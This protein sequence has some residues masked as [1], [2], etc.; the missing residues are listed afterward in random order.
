VRTSIDDRRVRAILI[1]LASLAL[2]DCGG[3]GEGGSA[4]GCA[5]GLETHTGAAVFSGGMSAGVSSVPGII[6]HGEPVTISGSGFGVKS[7]ALPAV[8]DGASGTNILDKWDGF[9]PS[10]NATYNLAYRNLPPCLSRPH[11]RASNRVISGAH[12]SSGGADAGFNV[13]FWK[14]RTITSYPAYTYASWYQRMDNNWVFGSDDNLKL[15]DFSLGSEPYNQYNWYINWN[16][17]PHNAVSATSFGWTDDGVGAAPPLSSL[18]DPDQ[19]GHNSFWGGGGVNPMS[20]WAKVEIEIKYTNANDGY[21]KMWENGVLQMNYLG[22][23]DKYSGTSRSES[24]GGFAR[25]RSTNNWRYFAEVYLDYTPA[26]VVLAN[27]PTLSLATIVENQ[28]PTAWS[29]TSITFVINLGRFTTGQTAYVFVI[30]PSGV[31]DGPGR[32]VT[33][34]Q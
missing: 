3:G 18:Q 27:N 29:N 5:G 34:G 30:T 24:I 1:V 21:I 32:P 6:N 19:N 31:P 11:A 22:S 33:V 8:L 10:Q 20:G 12:Y 17:G 7:P 23:T 25:S 16:D 15:W 4:A 13:M 2:V 26:R 28:I 14:N 9:W